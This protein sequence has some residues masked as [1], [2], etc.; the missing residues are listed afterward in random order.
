[1]TPASWHPLR[2]G[3]R[4]YTLVAGIMVALLAILGLAGNA[5]AAQAATSPTTT[6]TVHF[7]VKMHRAVAGKAGKASP[8]DEVVI[9]DCTVQ[10]NNAHESGHNPGQVNVTGGMV[11]A[12]YP[13]A[14]ADLSLG[15]YYNGYEYAYDDNYLTDVYVN[16][17]QANTTCLPGTYYATLDYYIYFGPTWTPETWDGEVA[18]PAQA[19]TC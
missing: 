17:V 3:R 9:N 12:P 19:I 1:M 6:S 2:R 16:P 14:Q 7:T 8:A 13:V 10:V 18:S 4:K 15:L 5:G 11:C